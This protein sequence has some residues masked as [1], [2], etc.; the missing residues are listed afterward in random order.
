MSTEN[1]LKLLSRLYAVLGMDADADGYPAKA[2]LQFSRAQSFPHK[3]S[4]S[5][6]DCLQRLKERF[7]EKWEDRGISRKKIFSQAFALAMRDLMIRRKTIVHQIPH[8]NISN[9]RRPGVLE[10]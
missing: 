9:K 7:L 1:R 4:V 10:Y 6:E 8:N 3:D 5:P 2:Y